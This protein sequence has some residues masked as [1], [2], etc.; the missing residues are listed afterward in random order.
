MKSE[1]Y[2]HIRDSWL[3]NGKPPAVSVD[4]DGVAKEK[5]TSAVNNGAEKVNKGGRLYSAVN[6]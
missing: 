1:A 3:D 6:T 2:S 5:I 4:P